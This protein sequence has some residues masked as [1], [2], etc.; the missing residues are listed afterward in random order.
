MDVVIYNNNWYS[1]LR[2]P[3]QDANMNQV[4]IE[5]VTGNLDLFTESFRVRDHSDLL[6]KIQL[7][8]KL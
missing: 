2:V 3:L 8:P 7:K 4:F 6:I 5:K 1:E